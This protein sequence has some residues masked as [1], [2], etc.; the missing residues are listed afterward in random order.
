MG[1]GESID[2]VSNQ[3]VSFSFYINQTSHYSDMPNREYD[4]HICN[5]DSKNAKK[6]V[7]T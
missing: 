2:P 4:L 6:Q 7:L 3:C 1:E 5:F